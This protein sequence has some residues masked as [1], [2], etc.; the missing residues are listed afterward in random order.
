MIG[1]EADLSSRCPVLSALSQ[2]FLC[3]F[4]GSKRLT[5]KDAENNG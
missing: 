3:E 2:A 1:G 5:A 4:G